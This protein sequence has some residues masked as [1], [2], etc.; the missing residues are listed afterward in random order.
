MRID[1]F[2]KN[3]ALEYEVVDVGNMSFLARLG[4]RMKGVK[5]PAICSGEKMLCGIPSDEEVKKLLRG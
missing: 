5:T 4:L 3:K 2:C 1:N